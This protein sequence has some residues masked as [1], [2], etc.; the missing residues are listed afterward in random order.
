[1]RRVRAEAA[2]AAAAA[3]AAW[4][5]KERQWAE[6]YVPSDGPA[7]SDGCEDDSD[8]D[9]DGKPASTVQPVDRLVS[10]HGDAHMLAV[11]AGKRQAAWAVRF[12]RGGQRKWRW[13]FLGL[14]FVDCSGGKQAEQLVGFSSSCLCSSSDD[15]RQLAQLD[16]RDMPDAEQSSLPEQRMCS[17]CAQLLAAYGG[18][19]SMRRLLRLC[20]PGSSASVVAPLSVGDRQ[21]LA[22]RAGACF[23]DWGVVD[24]TTRRCC[25][26]P[27][28]LRNCKHVREV[29]QRASATAV[30]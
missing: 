7:D 28:R 5:E 4:L 11:S 21:Y 3:A 16:G 22:V 13:A 9:A 23:D 12:R 10:R 15:N 6:E 26:C 14:R 24:N 1:M 27:T 2:A 8:S 20:T 18:S 29:L 30:T 25:V 19:A 17:C